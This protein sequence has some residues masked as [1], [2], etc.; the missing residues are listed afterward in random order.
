MTRLFEIAK[1]IAVQAIFDQSHDLT[2]CSE[3]LEGTE[4]QDADGQISDGVIDDLSIHLWEIGEWLEDEL[5]PEK[6]ENAVG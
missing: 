1:E 5:T 3:A 4:Y 2:G 6:K